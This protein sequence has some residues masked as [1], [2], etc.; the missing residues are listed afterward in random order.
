MTPLQYSCLENPMDGGAW[1]AT[2][3]SVAKSQTRLKQLNKTGACIGIS[4]VKVKVAQ[5]CLTLCN[6]MDYR[7]QGTLLTRIEEWVAFA[8]SDIG[9]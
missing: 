8:F 9:R 1:R 7:V 5:S 3:H 2:V 4:C 6:P